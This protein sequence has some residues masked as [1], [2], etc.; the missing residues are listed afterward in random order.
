MARELVNLTTKNDELEEQV[1]ELPQ[2][3]ENYA[4]SE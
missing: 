3:K 1:V 2:L 4:V